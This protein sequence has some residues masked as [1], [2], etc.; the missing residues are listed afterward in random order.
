MPPRIA[1]PRS[2]KVVNP[3]SDET[4]ETGVPPE[5]S[6]PPIFIDPLHGN[7][8]ACYLDKD[9]EHASEISKLVKRYGGSISTSHNNASYILVD[10]TTESG[11]HLFR[12]LHNGKKGKT[13]LDVKWVQMCIDAKDVLGYKA[14]WGGCRVTGLE[15]KEFLRRQ[16]EQLEQ[17]STHPEIPD[18]VPQDAIG[19][20]AEDHSRTPPPITEQHDSS[21]QNSP[22]AA[23]ESPDRPPH[24]VFYPP[25]VYGY[26]PM[27]PPR[28]GA[29]TSHVPPPMVPMPGPWTYLPNGQLMPVP[30]MPMFPP[31]PPPP[32]PLETGEAAPEGQTAPQVPMA[33]PAYDYQQVQGYSN[34][35]MEYYAQQ[36]DPATYARQMEGGEYQLHPSIA[37]QGSPSAKRNRGRTRTRNTQKAPSKLTLKTLVPT[38]RSPSP[39]TRVVKSTY[40]GNLFTDED[41]EYLKRY[42]EYCQQQGLLL[43]LR[44][45]CERLATKAPHH[46]FF[47][48][49]RYCNK[50]QIRLG[51][52]VMEDRREN[53]NS[54]EGDEVSGDEGEAAAAGPST[55]TPSKRTRNGSPVPPKILYKSTTG[56]GVAF[57]AE[58]VKY[59][60]DYM[61]HRKETSPHLDMVEFWTDL[62]ERAPHHSRASWMKYWRRHRHELEEQGDQPATPVQNPLAKKQRYTRKDDI[63]LARYM[64][65]LPSDNQANKKTSDAIFQDFA[66]LH[67][68][69]PWKGWQE[70]HR[71][72]KAQIDHIMKD[73]AE[74]V[75][76][77]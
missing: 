18:E 15:R 74:G 6:D 24:S 46:T 77:S 56:K 44:E 42:I 61:K 71:I 48:W 55:S 10:P 20:P 65:Q 67:P 66:N 73:I 54:E 53:E 60:L 8:L 35:W 13:I 22:T 19:Q 45:I 76:I 75:E 25:L 39:P 59:M 28:S 52:Y 4:S 38:A 37:V 29:S 69:H 23:Q 9:V 1:P 36:M 64:L 12:T 70:H 7:A 47:S 33:Y 40:G 32:P 49:R 5:D 62:A 11:H 3:L 30:M 43:S 72:H 41:V 26:P 17:G 31:V 50:H 58:D 63:L 16:K 27:P 34:A 68:H 51:A 57:T 14:N 2:R 21:P